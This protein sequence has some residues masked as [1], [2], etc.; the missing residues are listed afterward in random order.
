MSDRLVQIANTKAGKGDTAAW[1]QRLDAR[2]AKA[3]QALEGNATRS[4]L[5][6]LLQISLDPSNTNEL[7]DYA[8]DRVGDVRSKEAIPH[9]WPMFQ[10]AGCAGSKCDAAGKLEKRL[11]WRAGEMILSI[12]GPGIITEFLKRMP[13]QGGVQYEPEEL[14]GYATVSYTHL[15][16]PTTPY[17]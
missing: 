6:R 3:L 2:R 14:E 5:K 12:G 17:V 10:R 7:R 9:L 1:K 13:G 11:R 4:H 16:L 15:T 8:F